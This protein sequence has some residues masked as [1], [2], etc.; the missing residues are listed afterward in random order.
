[1]FLIIKQRVPGVEFIYITKDVLVETRKSLEER[2]SNAVTIPG[3][4]SFHEFI[5]L[6]ENT[7]AMK[8][9]SKDEEVATTFSFSHEMKVLQT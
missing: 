7:I 3:S 8:Y 1:M 6:T 4:R 5:P 9:C 2:F